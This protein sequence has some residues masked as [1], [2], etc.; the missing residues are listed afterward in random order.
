MIE[1]VLGILVAVITIIGGG[2]G[3]YS[4]LIRPKRI[5]TKLQMLLA[6]IQE[7]FDEIDCNLENG[8]NMAALNN[9]E[10]KIHEYISA[11]LGHYKIEPT[12]KLIRTWNKKMGLRSDFLESTEE[13][14]RY[15]RVSSDGISVE[16]FFVMLVANFTTFHANYPPKIPGACNFAE[17]EM[18]VKFFR[19]FVESL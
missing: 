5:R 6:M 1:S 17:V 19:F 13:F 11:N 18:P 2:Y 7:W 14:M 9:K 12:E 10:N 4:K 16:L 15:S 8:L 3:C